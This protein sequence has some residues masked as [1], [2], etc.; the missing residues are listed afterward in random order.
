VPAAARASSAACAFIA[1][2]LP[3]L[4]ESARAHLPQDGLARSD[5]LAADLV[6]VAQSR[7][8]KDG[9]VLGVHHDDEKL[10]SEKHREVTSIE[11]SRLSQFRVYGQANCYAAVT[12]S[13]RNARLGPAAHRFYTPGRI[14][15]H[16]T[17]LSGPGVRRQGRLSKASPS[18]AK[19]WINQ[20]CPSDHPGE[21]E[22][23]GY[24]GSCSC[25]L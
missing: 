9:A 21:Q 18:F 20:R 14:P 1:P 8:E 17:L 19:R 3:A 24:S 10:K 5:E 23:H 25:D 22:I 13:N 6:A 11:V 12:I 2:L 15:S 4:R 16:D 7:F